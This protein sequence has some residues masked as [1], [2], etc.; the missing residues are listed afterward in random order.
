LK[1]LIGDKPG[2]E[3]TLTVIGNAGVHRIPSK[4]CRGEL[5]EVSRGSWDV[6]SAEQLNQLFSELLVGLARKLRER[7]W[8]TI[9]FVPTGHPALSIQVKTLIYRILRRNTVDLYHT[10]G[11]YFEIE[12]DHRQIAL[13]VSTEDEGT[14]SA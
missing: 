7:S 6:E 9:Y 1:G 5:Y 13:D 11:A 2:D 8:R 10:D 14:S 4:Y 3:D 12:I